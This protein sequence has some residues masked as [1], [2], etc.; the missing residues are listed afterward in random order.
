[1]SRV[2][3]FGASQLERSV[4]I[5]FSRLLTRIANK[6]YVKEEKKPKYVK[7]GI[8]HCLTD[9]QVWRL[10]GNLKRGE[11]KKLAEEFGVNYTYA[12]NVRSGYLRGDVW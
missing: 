9:D 3:N 4:A 1:M 6:S 2:G 11:L 12:S 5:T 10:R 8:K 7:K